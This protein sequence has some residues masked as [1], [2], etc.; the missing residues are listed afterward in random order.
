LVWRFYPSQGPPITKTYSHAFGGDMF[1][2]PAEGLIQPNGQYAM[3]LLLPGA[4]FSRDPVQEVKNDDRLSRE[5]TGLNSL[6]AR[7]VKWSV[8][9]DGV[10]FSNGVYVGPDSAKY[11]D[12]VKAKYGG[13]RDLIQE[14]VDKINGNQ[15]YASIF[16][17]AQSYASIT[18]K[19]LEAP[20]PDFRTRMT[21]PVYTYNKIK[22]N[23]GRHII[24]RRDRYGEQAAIDF[25]IQNSKLQI[26]LVKH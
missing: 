14:L 18:D 19:D 8:D 26:P 17:H 11:F 5:L 10:L 12:F 13:G 15:P 20:F 22:T 7:S 3:S 16:A 24:A 23:M 4:G 21:D 25:I 9:V 2:N 1:T 6:I